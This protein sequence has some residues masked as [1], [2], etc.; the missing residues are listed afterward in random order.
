MPSIIASGLIAGEKIHG[1]DRQTVFFTAVDPMEKFWSIT[2]EN[3]I[4]L[5]P[6]TPRTSMYGKSHKMQFIGLTLVVLSER[7]YSSNRPGRTRSFSVTLYLQ[8]AL[9][10][11]YQDNHEILYTRISKSPRPAY[12]ITLKTDGQRNLHHNAEAAA[13]SS[14][15]A[16][17]V[18]PVNL[19]S[20][21]K[22]DQQKERE[23]KNEDEENDQAN[24]GKP[25]TT[26]LDQNKGTRRQI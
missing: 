26:L 10:E 14:Q 21:S 16:R 15:L 1:R 25:V 9:K 8:Y 3:I 17:M 5:N 2:K 20:R 19:K 24:T 23:A 13:S 22:F 11:W 4:C 18:K 12:T 6:G 7:H